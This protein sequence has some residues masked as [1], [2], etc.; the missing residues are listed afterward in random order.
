MRAKARTRIEVAGLTAMLLALPATGPARAEERTFP[1]GELGA[2]QLLTTSADLELVGWDRPEVRIAGPKAGQVAHEALPGLLRLR[3]NTDLVV[4]LPAGLK[5]DVEGVSGDVK[6]RGLG[7]RLRIQTVSG[8]VDVE[9]AAGGLEVV[10]VSGDVV[11]RRVRGELSLRTIS[12]DQR[13]ADIESERLEASSVSGEIRV[14]GGRLREVRFKSHSGDVEFDGRIE[15]GGQVRLSSFSG[16]V[17]VSLPRGTGFEVE[18]RTTSGAIQVAGEVQWAERSP[19]FARGRVGQ[20]D[21]ELRLGTRSGD[22]RVRL[23][24]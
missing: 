13:L 11:A 20:G 21:R 18:A 22:V 5:V 9:G 14:R 16:D 6:A 24:D 17:L 7:G 23:V 10:T 12:G 19:R 15:P 3:G 2:V 8:D 4:H 1:V